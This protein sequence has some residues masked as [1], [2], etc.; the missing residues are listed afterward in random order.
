MGFT[1][2]RGGA[3]RAR[4]GPLRGFQIFVERRQLIK[5][6]ADARAS[7]S[8]KAS[9]TR[10]AAS[11]KRLAYGYFNAQYPPAELTQFCWTR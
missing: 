3:E 7:A 6:L 11:K 2:R 9:G 8:H 4:V 1:R 5:R 10:S